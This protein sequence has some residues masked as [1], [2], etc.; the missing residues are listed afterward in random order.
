MPCSEAR[1][2]CLCRPGTSNYSRL[3]VNCKLMSES[4][5]LFDV[6]KYKFS[7]PPK[8]DSAVVRVVPLGPPRTP[9]FDMQE[10][11]AMLKRC[12][13]GRNKTLRSLFSSKYLLAALEAQRQAVQ[14]TLRAA[15]ASHQPETTRAAAASA[16]ATIQKV[17]QHTRQHPPLS[18]RTTPSPPPALPDVSP[19]R[20]GADPRDAG[21]GR[22]AGFQGQRDAGD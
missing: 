5:L 3:S 7:P 11:D 14:A 4:T 2:A 12:F 18:L 1:R 10:W 16:A 13:S 6:P 15:Q 20:E 8:V 19:G 17:T 22:S 9:G 21:Q